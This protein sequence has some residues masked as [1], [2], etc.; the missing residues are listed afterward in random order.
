MATVATNLKSAS[1]V[2]VAAV[3]IV[4][5]ALSDHLDLIP[6]PYRHW[7]TVAI[8]VATLLGIYQAPHGPLPSLL[9][10]RGSASKP[11]GRKRLSRKPA[12][13]AVVDHPAP[14]PHPAAKANPQ[15][16]PGAHEK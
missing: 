12:Q 7:V 5:A 16:K 8:G 13:P 15:A 1:K 11:E 6:D 9:G 3:G 14:H 10:N 2:I 4:L